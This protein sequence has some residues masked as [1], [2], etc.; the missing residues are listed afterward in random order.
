MHQTIVSVGS[1]VE[2][3]KN[4]TLSQEI[5]T[6]EVTFQAAATII[7]TKPDGYQDQPDFLNGAY[8]LQ[9]KMSYDAFNAYLKKLEKRMGRVKG[10][11]KSGPRCIDIDIIVWDGEIVHDDYRKK[12]HYVL[13]PVNEII[14]QHQLNVNFDL[15]VV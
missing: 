7:K 3:R 4:F 5:L 8:L 2:P 11:I 10:P 6:K 14:E 15:F 1:N 9:T 12:K 13:T